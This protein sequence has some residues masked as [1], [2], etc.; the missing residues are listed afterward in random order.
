MEQCLPLLKKSAS[1]RH[2][3][4]PARLFMMFSSFVFSKLEYASCIWIFRVFSAHKVRCFDSD[5]NS[6]SFL[7]N[8][9]P[10]HGYCKHWDKLN[11]IFMKCMRFIIGAHCSASNNAV[12]VRLGVMPLHYMLAYRASLWFLKIF[13]DE[14]DPLLFQQWRDVSSDDEI[15]MLTSMYKGCYRFVTRL[16]ELIEEDIFSC[17]VSR[18]IEILRSAMFEDLTSHWKNLDEARVTH[19]VHERWQA[20]NFHGSMV[21][22]YSHTVY[23]NAALGRGP[24]GAIIHRDA[25]DDQLRKC[26]HGCGV[27]ETMEHALLECRFVDAQRCCLHESLKSSG[28]RLTIA[29]ALGEENVAE[30]CEKLFAS[31]LDV[32]KP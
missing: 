23:H 6:S 7:P 18:R 22:R 3:A 5:S 25:D 31:F 28:K 10:V 2:G 15:L 19:E 8:S 24:F 12:L 27:D 13:H 20:L 16:N 26:R 17:S 32:F 9:R 30:D 21:T 11:K 1:S 4:S 29:N 14:S